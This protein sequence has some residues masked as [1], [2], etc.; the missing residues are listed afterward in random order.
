M[1]IILILSAKYWG[2]GCKRDE[3]D[4]GPRCFSEIRCMR[5]MCAPGYTYWESSVDPNCLPM[6]A[7]LLPND[8]PLHPYGGASYYVQDAG[9]HET[10]ETRQNI[11]DEY[12]QI[13]SGPLEMLGVALGPANWD[14]IRRA[15]YDYSPFERE[16]PLPPKDPEAFILT[17]MLMY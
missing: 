12:L 10:K 4:I 2:Y 3:R 6:K 5:G 7:P 14:D 15:I 13:C 9:F 17:G 1:T 16:E 8:S 11:L